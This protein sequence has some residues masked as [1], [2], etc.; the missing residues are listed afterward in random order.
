MSTP[1]RLLFYKL[2]AVS[3][4]LLAIRY[5]LSAIGY[6][7]LAV[8]YSLS[9]RRPLITR[10]SLLTTCYSLL[11][12]LCVSC[13]DKLEIVYD[14]NATVLSIE[15]I[16]SDQAG[17]TTARIQYSKS[18]SKNVEIIPIKNCVVEIL[19]SGGS[20]I[21][22]KEEYDGYYVAPAAFKGVAGQTYQLQ[23]RTPEGKNYLSRTETL[24][25]APP[26]K[27]VYQQFNLNGLLDA[28]GSKTVASTSD[29]FLDFD[30]PAN[31]TN[32]YLWTWKQYEKHDVCESCPVGYLNSTTLKCVAV[33]Q[34]Y[35]TYPSYDYHCRGNCWD[36]AYNTDLNVLSDIYVKGRPVVGRPIA[37]I[38]FYSVENTVVEISQQSISKGAYE[39]YNLLRS[40]TENTGT[41]TD[42]P[43]APIIGNISNTATPSE[44]VVGYFLAAGSNK[45]SYYID[46]SA[47]LKEAVFTSLLGRPINYEPDLGP[48]S[49]PL[50][51]FRA[52][53]APCTLGKYR[54]PI[55]PNGWK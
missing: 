55:A 32:Y 34:Q 10:Y 25:S 8:C 35:G 42:T 29:V 15:G 26:I 2:L 18:D 6:W 48:A 53:R 27:K 46:R 54:T 43:P 30:D 12:F 22:L 33:K 44:V 49:P 23:I 14:L 28:T 24:T 41:L 52:P 39:Y 50:F 4:W 40:I 45:T 36:I 5:R 11:A 17:E 3:Y 19:V 13:V 9:E 37:K 16:V 31:A 38:P 1:F 21:T 47:N 20:K 7:L 51:E